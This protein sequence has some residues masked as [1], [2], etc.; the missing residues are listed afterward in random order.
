MEI[1]EPVCSFTL[2]FHV[3]LVSH[4]VTN[5]NSKPNSNHKSIDFRFPAPFHA[6]HGTEGSLS[7]VNFFS[8]P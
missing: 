8:L 3:R 6:N 2:I 5:D 4:R 1:L 7:R